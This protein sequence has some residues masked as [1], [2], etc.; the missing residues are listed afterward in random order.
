MTEHQQYLDEKM[1][2]LRVVCQAQ[3]DYLTYANLDKWLNDNFA[4]DIEGRY[5]ATKILLHTVYYTKRDL[6]KLLH[7]GLNELIYGEMV[8]SEMI[9]KQNI[10]VPA[11]VTEAKIEQLKQST[12]FVPLLDSKK[13][14]ESGNGII[15]DLVHKID[16]SEVQ[17]DFHWNITEEQLQNYKILV[18]VDDCIGSGSQLKRF[19]KSEEILRIRDICKRHGII[20]YYLVLV[21]YDA[22]VT[23]LVNSSQ[24]DGLKIVVCDLLTEKNRVFSDSNIIW[25][26]DTNEMQNAID[27]FEK[28]KKEKGASFLGFKNLDFAV[29]LHDRLPNWSLP[30]FWKKSNS[31]AILLKRKTSNS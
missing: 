11:S 30:I 28:T 7:Y 6:E 14:S 18:F 27:Y 17:V 10:Y 9:R 29:I 8:K 20:I 5:Y 4:N 24:I 2:Q 22:N 16:I 26:K 19:W 1:H 3:W 12:F 23:K 13:P 25:N 15:G 31:W 21:G